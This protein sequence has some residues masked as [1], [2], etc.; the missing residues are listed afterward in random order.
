MVRKALD[1]A[2]NKAQAA[3]TLGVSRSYAI[4]VASGSL[5]PGKRIT[6]GLG[7]V[8]VVRYED[9]APEG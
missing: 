7:L 9:A 3:R 8:R 4:R 1:A 6:A 2:P 5:R